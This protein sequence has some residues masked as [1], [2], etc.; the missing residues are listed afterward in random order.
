MPR[1]LPAPAER[2]LIAAAPV[3]YAISISG[4]GGARPAPEQ[5]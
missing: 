2:N 4:G 5:S 3:I 1:I